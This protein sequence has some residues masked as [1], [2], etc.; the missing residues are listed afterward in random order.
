MPIVK[1][2]IELLERGASFPIRDTSLYHIKSGRTLRDF[3]S[4]LMRQMV[5]PIFDLSKERKVVRENE[6]LA[7]IL[8]SL[9]DVAEGAE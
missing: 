3:R 7:C 4:T 2:S 6:E 8:G 9:L 1:Q 5:K